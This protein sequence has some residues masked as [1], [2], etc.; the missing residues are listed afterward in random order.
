M[1]VALGAWLL[2]SSSNV[3]VSSQASGD[4]IGL[5]TSQGSLTEPPAIPAV[6]RV[7]DTS[8][9]PQVQMI[10]TA[11]AAQISDA[12]KTYEF[13][14][15]FPPYSKPLNANNWNLLNPRPFIPRKQ[16]LEVGDGVQGVITLDSYVIHNDRPMNVTVTLSSE[17]GS[18]GGIDSVSAQLLASGERIAL[19]TEAHSHTSLHSNLHSNSH[20]NSSA[21]RVLTGGFSVDQIATLNS[22]EQSLLVQV[23]TPSGDVVNLSTQFKLVATQASLVSI[24]TAYVDGAHLMVPA[25]FSTDNPGKYRLQANVFTE[26]MKTPIAHVNETFELDSGET[27]TNLRVHAST[28]RLAGAAGPY[29]LTGI[30]LTKVSTKPGEP[31]LYGDAQQTSYSI[32]GFDLALYDDSEYSNPDNE[33]RLQ[34]LRNIS[35]QPM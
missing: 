11:I 17:S 23:T 21:S 10:E 30:N 18:V 7:K 19:Q 28:L 6:V 24:G 31:T 33:A 32:N 29:V 34:F 9:E 27:T 25:Q 12:A 16:A 26:D 15:K 5:K 22:G 20:S 4:D 35:G 2:S 14:S 1:V 13:N 8:S 3:S